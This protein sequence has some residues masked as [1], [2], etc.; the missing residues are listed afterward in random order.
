MLQKF[1]SSPVKRLT[2]GVEI[3][4]ALVLAYFLADL[5]GS[6][7]NDA[8]V[9]PAVPPPQQSQ[10]AA[11]AKGKPV[12]EE[13]FTKLFGTEVKKAAPQPKAVAPA[14]PKEAPPPTPLKIQIRGILH[15]PDNPDGSRAIIYS[16]SRI[17]ED[18]FGLGDWLWDGE[19]LVREI[20]SDRVVFERGDYQE[21]VWLDGKSEIRKL[22]GEKMVSQAAPKPAASAALGKAKY[23]PPRGGANYKKYDKNS[24]QAKK[25]SKVRHSLLT[26]P[27]TVPNLVNYR[28]H[29]N[30]EG[31]MEGVV[32]NPGSDFG[33]LNKMGFYAEDMITK[34][35]GHALNDLDV[36]FGL[37]TNLE[38]MESLE[39]DVIRKGRALHVSIPFTN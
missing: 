32:L 36:L 15:L 13:S 14:A 4:L 39:L 33:L 34:V 10:G 3:A 28:L 1:S 21:T 6:I 9:T 24:F 11:P 8:A 29:Y 12:G 7:M 23:K 35:N 16:V 25:I 31:V 5:A 17:T 2:K 19:G 38:N 27:E 26:E 30:K 20:R 37:F 18:F 22:S